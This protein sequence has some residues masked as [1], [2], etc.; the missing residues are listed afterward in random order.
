[1][2]QKLER[3][4]RWPVANGDIDGDGL[5]DG[6]PGTHRKLPIEVLGSGAP[7]AP[8]IA[9]AQLG[10]DPAKMPLAARLS[11]LC[12]RCG[13]Y[14]PPE[15]QALA[16]PLTKVKA[17]VRIVGNEGSGGAQAPWIDVTEANVHLREVERAH[18]GFHGGMVTARFWIAID[19]AT[20]A[21]L[22]GLPSTNRIEFRFNGTEG[23][24]NGY[25]VLDVQLQDENGVDLNAVPIRQPGVGGRLARAHG[26]AVPPGVHHRRGR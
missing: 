24:S 1:M 23:S 17:S 2:H 19:P 3:R 20:R 18:G 11:V 10:L 6:P 22:V 12:H 26:L 15:F 7:D 8:V 25:R 5:D 16:K 4:W 14:D 13:Y 21:R 9:R